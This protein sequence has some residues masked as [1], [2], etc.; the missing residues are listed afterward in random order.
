MRVRVNLGVVSA[1]ESEGVRVR[2]DVVSVR[3]QKADLQARRSHI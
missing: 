3:R 1:S 2:V